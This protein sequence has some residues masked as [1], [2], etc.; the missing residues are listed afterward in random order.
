[1]LDDIP[2]KRKKEGKEETSPSLRLVSFSLA[3]DEAKIK[4]NQIENDFPII[5]FIFLS[6]LM[7]SYCYLRLSYASSDW[8]ANNSIITHKF[9]FPWLF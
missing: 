2:L 4:L 8:I 9:T 6:L 5:S 1:M 7:V 3:S